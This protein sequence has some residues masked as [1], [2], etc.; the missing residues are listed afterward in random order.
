[1]KKSLLR[2]IYPEYLRGKSRSFTLIELVVAVAIFMVAV[3]LVIAA[4]GSVFNSKYK[5]ENISNVQKNAENIIQVLTNEVLGSNSCDSF[6]DSGGMQ[7]AYYFGLRAA[8][9][10]FAAADPPIRP[11]GTISS[12]TLLT[13][14]IDPHY[15]KIRKVFYLDSGNLRMSEF[16]NPSGYYNS[17]EGAGQYRRQINDTSVRIDSI[18]F[19]TSAME[20]L[21][22]DVCSTDS[23]YHPLAQNFLEVTM[24]LTSR[25]PDPRGNYST[26]TVRKFIGDKNLE[27][28][29]RSQ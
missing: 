2:V 26:V 1:M 15:Q 3:T 28:K 5:T 13:T 25:I 9:P 18:R 29:E 11:R 20:G 6:W 17:N 21:D 24:T 12:S 27:Y 22:S 14:K 23:S 7:V 10:S 4:S 16:I 19:S 8:N